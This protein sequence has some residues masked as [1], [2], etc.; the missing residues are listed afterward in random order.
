MPGSLDAVLFVVLVLAGLHDHFRRWPRLKRALA[1][2]EPQARLRHYRAVLVEEWVLAALVA[3]LW[4]GERRSWS[5]LWLAPPSGWRLVLAFVLVLPVT[6][7]F[8]QQSRALPRIPPE[9]RAKLRPKLSAVADLLPHTR[10]EY[11]AFSALSITAGLCEEFLFRGYLVWLFQPWLGLFGAAALSV[12]LFGLGHL[13]QGKKP[14]TRAAVVGLALA[15]IALG[16][17]SLLPGMLLHAVIDL[18]AGALGFAL[19]REARDVDALQLR[20]RTSE[21]GH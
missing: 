19:F 2:G 20:Q 13:Y 10:A 17:G 8:V 4:I 11:H 12:V 6:A 18:N 9:R 21:A 1:A 14:G 16:T 5:L 3:A 15:L 7:L